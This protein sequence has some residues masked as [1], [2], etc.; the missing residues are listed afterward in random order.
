MVHLDLWSKGIPCI[1]ARQ[2]EW[3][4]PQPGPR[5]MSP[6]P[7]WISSSSVRFWKYPRKHSVSKVVLNIVKLTGKISLQTSHLGI[8]TNTKKDTH[9]SGNAKGLKN[10]MPGK[11]E[12]AQIYNSSHYHSPCQCLLLFLLLPTQAWPNQT[13]S[14]NVSG[15]RVDGGG[16]KLKILCWS[17]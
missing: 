1:K 6:H 14:P 9:H 13:I 16:I 3:H 7:G 12:E 10:Y 5:C 15:F 4:G 11:W 2:W 8:Q 17:N